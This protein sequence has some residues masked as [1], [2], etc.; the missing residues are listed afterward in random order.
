MGIVVS[1]ILLIFLLIK[2]PAVQNY[3]L[4][5]VTAYL[6]KKID[7]PF[8]IGR[9]DLDLPKLL[10]LEDVYI[11]DRTRDTLVAGEKLAVDINLLRLFNNVVEINRVDLIGITANVNRTLPDSAFNFAYI[12]DAFIDPDRPPPPDSVAPMVINIDR[13]NLE[14]IRI[15]YH[16][17]VLGL[18]TRLQLNELKTRIGKF[19]LSGDMHFAV[20]QLKVGGLSGH[21]DQWTSAPAPADTSLY[22]LAADT[23][24]LPEEAR[25]PTI[26]LGSIALAD[27]DF[28]YRNRDMA[29]D[30]RFEI[31]Q[32]DARLE[33]LDLNNTL[34]RIDH[35]RLNN[36]RSHVIFGLSATNP[37]LND[38][39]AG[40][41]GITTGT[42]E[43]DNG[44]Q[45]S[46][47]EI[48]IQETDF[49]YRDDN[50][51]RIPKGFDYGNIRITDLNGELRAL[52]YSLDSISGDLRQLSAKDGSGLEVHRLES[53]F[54]YTDQGVELAGLYA[55]TPHTRIRD[56]IQIEYP[57]L[58]I[59]AERPGEIGI[60]ADL[61]RS[62]LGMQDIL[63]FLPD[64]DTVA[65]M[66]PLWA[67]TFH[68]DG[69]IR[70]RVDD[71][72]IPSLRINTLDYTVIDAQAHL[73]GLPDIEHLDAE[74]KI[75]TLTTGKADLD[76]LIAK[77]LLPD[78][79]RLPASISLTGT[80]EGGMTGFDTDLQLETSEGNA[81]LEGLFR[82]TN[83]SGAADTT[84]QGRL[85]IMDIDLGRILNM[86]ST[87][88]TFSF[89]A[90]VDGRGLDPKTA[91]AKARAEL[92]GLQ[93]LGYTYQDIRIDAESNEGALRVTA[94]SPDPNIDFDLL[95]T[96]HLGGE[97]LRLNL[98]LMIDSINLK[99]LHLM[100]EE[101]RYH[102][103]LV[104]D[105][106][107]ADIDYLNGTVEI[108]NSSIAY[109]Q[110]RYT[111]DSVKLTASADEAS[112]MM[113]LTSEF[114]NAHLVGNYQ[115]SQLNP[116]I[117]DIVA[118]YYQPDSIAPTYVYAPQQFD[119]S[120]TL[121]RSRFIRDFLPDLTEMEDVLLDGSFNSEDKFLLAKATAPRI[122][123]AGTSIENV[124][125]DITTFDS[126]MYYTAL[127]ERIA[128]SEI[129]LSNTL[130]SG[131]VLQN[132]LDFG[133]W[134]KDQEDEERYHLG[135]SLVADAGDFLFS[136]KDDGLMLNYDQW[137]VHPENSIAFGQKGVR[138]NNFTLSQNGQQLSARSQDSSWNAPID[139]V[140]DNF[141]IETFSKM[142]ESDILNMGGG[143]NGKATVSRL[144]S[145]PLFVSDMNID[146]F[147]FGR[148]TVGDILIKVHNEKEHS[149]TA[150]VEIVGNGNKI[151]LAGDFV[152]PPDLTPRLDFM[153]DLQPLN[154]QTLEAFSLGYIRNTSGNLTGQVSITGTAEAPLIDGT[155]TFNQTELNIAML[156]ATIRADQQRI[157]FDRQGIRFNRFEL[158]DRR[159]NIARLDGTIGTKTYPAFDFNLALT[160]NDFQLLNSTQQDNDLFYGQLFVSSNLKVSGSLSNPV[161][162]GS[163]R[164]D[165]NTDVTF[166]LPNEDPGL[167][168]REGI[169]K[170]VDRSD[171]THFNVFA[172]LDSLR[173]TEIS[174]LRLSM[175]IQTD[176]SAAFSIV[177][178][179]GSE[180]ALN[181]RGSADLT[182]GIDPSGD[183]TLTGTYTVQDGNYSFTFEPVKRVFNFRQGSTIT[184]TGDPMDAQ[185][186][187]TAVYKL[188]APTLELVQSQ[189][190][191]DAALYKQRVPFDVNLG[192]TGQML[193]PQLNF[194]IDLDEDNALVSQDV[195]TKVTTAL[196]QL[197]ENESEMNKQVFALIVLGRFM[198]ANPFESL[199]GGGVESMARNSVSSLLS[200]QL[201]RLAGDLIKG[202]E[203]DF[204]LQSGS[205]Y[206]TGT[207]QNR[208]DL[209]IG[210]SKMLFDDRLKVTIGSNFELEGQARP[211]EQTTNIAGDISVD[212]QLSKDGRYLLRV[213]RKN[214]Y[215]VTLQGQFIETGVGFI[216][217]MDYDE[218]SEIFSGAKEDADMF[219]TDTRQFRQRFDR[220]RMQTDSLYRDSVRRVMRDSLERTDPEFRK[221]MEERRQRQRAREKRRRR[222]GDTTAWLLREWDYPVLTVRE[223][224][225]RYDHD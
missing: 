110:E 36:S 202:I 118:V 32:L 17:E 6:E 161:V 201:N 46:A 203:L 114:L 149:Y 184:W 5:Q 76:R 219:S 7:T 134:I 140:F 12:I 163:L 135:M 90:T 209:N 154:M 172:R 86:D 101:F 34:V 171:T 42:D 38:S 64:L 194:W 63:Y 210:V 99:N 96:G 61:R 107:T 122:I 60:R 148:D 213:Y 143:I 157:T 24:P 168:E 18:S 178:D 142:L 191:S 106:E 77:G 112:T 189:V 214:Q 1:L 147:Y 164:V 195:A 141:R 156:N 190:G 225:W 74:L 133:L 224:E 59:I 126:T 158:K 33:E 97:Y 215:Q 40:E 120:A 82:T 116:A 180:D 44:W 160:A 138:A 26:E 3:L 192:I 43:T 87:L 83:D 119:F 35:I 197:E 56:F 71:L 150:Q 37:T 31:G 30:T 222:P 155:I 57:S 216:I 132:Q 8:R 113:Q 41:N 104:A 181:I 182:A 14:R 16:D 123:Y 174:G 39:T 128:I 186:D 51:P 136:L 176:E 166:V 165:E 81:A 84:Y 58:D 198:A 102:G 11:E 4:T 205:D 200:S 146:R 88:G 223:E 212:Y 152:A 137:E 218:F 220:E 98:R 15:G 211:G 121:K 183:I 66:D 130:L 162:N 62:H 159:N 89:A 48:R 70:G 9:I 125:F 131:T 20:P 127:I 177:L 68:V 21:L 55:E 204:D 93:A 67:R 45:V 47:N 73:R 28:T 100:E 109:N 27:I 145:N 85:A 50:Q 221:R 206:S 95:A 54:S 185:L 108:Q 144:E 217:N 49:I 79:I 23:G 187:I 124:S 193:Q 111:F 22:D 170:F 80:F 75:R 207:M 25:L 129:E 115:L 2:I 103:L 188:R 199:S 29:L 13:I 208:T 69:Q 19:D 117:Q 179:A 10:V 175:N 151:R 167:V 169:I 72:R 92:I 173:T 65:V 52:Y 153:L 105:L 196:N 53:R 78:S 91:T 94:D 139:F